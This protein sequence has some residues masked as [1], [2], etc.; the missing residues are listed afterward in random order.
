MANDTLTIPG[1]KSGLV[2]YNNLTYDNKFQIS[3]TDLTVLIVFV[4][5]AEAIIK[6]IF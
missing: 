3:P 4:V 5:L 1:S 2:S 6:L